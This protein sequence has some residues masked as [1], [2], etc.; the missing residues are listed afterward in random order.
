MNPSDGY[1]LFEQWKTSPQQKLFEFPVPIPK[2]CLLPFKATYQQVQSTESVDNSFEFPVAINRNLTRVVM[3]GGAL[4]LTKFQGAKTQLSAYNS[5]FQSIDFVAI[6]AMNAPL[7]LKGPEDLTTFDIQI[8]ESGKYVLV[9]HKSKDLVEIT[10]KASCQIRLAVV[11]VDVQNDDERCESD[12]RFLKSLALK[13]GF[14]GENDQADSTM[15][16]HPTLPVVVVKYA[17]YVVTR[18]ASE[19]VPKVRTSRRRRGN[20]GVWDI[21]SGGELTISSSIQGVTKSS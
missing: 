15:L 2:G 19:T 8:S 9:V 14:N 10:Q 21:S 5:R 16:L 6:A 18:S 7:N 12:Y 4:K 17:D 11:Y 3:P 20:A 13:P 1:V